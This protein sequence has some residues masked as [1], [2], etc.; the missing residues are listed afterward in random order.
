MALICQVLDDLD[1]YEKYKKPIGLDQNWFKLEDYKEDNKQENL[2]GSLIVFALNE[3][4]YILQ[5]DYKD[6]LEDYYS[7]LKYFWDNTKTKLVNLC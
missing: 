6:E 5:L 7:S 2:L 3:K 4:G 1:F